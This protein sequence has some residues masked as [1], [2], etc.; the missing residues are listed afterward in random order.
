MEELN[1][2]PKRQKDTIKELLDKKRDMA[3]RGNFK[4]PKIRNWGK[5]GKKAMSA[6]PNHI[7][8]VE[9]E[10]DD[11]EAKSSEVSEFPKDTHKRR[12]HVSK[13]PRERLG[14]RASA[15]WFEQ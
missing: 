1:L 15:S 3:I 9:E 14:L 11:E 10:D 4:L 2:A 13:T 8:T 7:S 12:E 6:F 5:R